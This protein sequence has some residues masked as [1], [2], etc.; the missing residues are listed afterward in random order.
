MSSSSCVWEK[1]TKNKAQPDKAAAAF[2]Q[3]LKLNPKLIAAATKLAQL[4]AGPLQNKEKALAYAKKARELAPADPQVAG[5]SWKGCVPKWQFHLGLQPSAG[6]RPP[7]P[8]R[9]VSP[10]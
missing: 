2:E 8:K 1:L 7:A 4:Y 6:S 3:A 10:I 9:S 5:Y